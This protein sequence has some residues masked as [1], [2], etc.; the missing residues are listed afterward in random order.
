MIRS[1]FV[2]SRRG[3][4]RTGLG[5]GGLML[6]PQARACEFFTETLRVTHPYC[7]ASQPGSTE[8][9]VCMKFDEVQRR[10]RLV[11]VQT[12]VA[13]GAEIAGKLARPGVDFEIP[14]GEETWLHERGT[15][16]RLTGLRQPLHLGR[17]Y[18][19][20][21]DFEHGGTVLAQLTVDFPSLRFS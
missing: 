20:Q 14:Q 6:L 8:A 7:H 10:D 17:A 3:W 2:V 4:L 9:V 1:R 5:L 19:L 16:L 21:L 12:P 13:E 11:G 18:P 15:W